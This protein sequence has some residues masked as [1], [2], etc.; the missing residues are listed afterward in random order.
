MPR[1][2]LLAAIM[3]SLFLEVGCLRVKVDP[4]HVTVDVNIR[5]QKELD[6][7]F[8]DLDA[9]DSTIQPKQK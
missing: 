9:A 1:L 8:D 2:I 3:G 4:I 6:N 7:F 5:V